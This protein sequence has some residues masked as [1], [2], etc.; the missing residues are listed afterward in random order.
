M[1][2][3]IMIIRRF[4]VVCLLFGNGLTR[5]FYFAGIKTKSRKWMIKIALTGTE[6]MN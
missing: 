3:M 4:L 2:V 5:V 1:N 6:N